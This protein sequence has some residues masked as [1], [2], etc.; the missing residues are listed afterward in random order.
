MNINISG[1]AVIE[2]RWSYFLSLSTFFLYISFQ[3][4]RPKSQL[5]LFLAQMFDR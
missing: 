2:V 3:R 5:K 1:L 4:V